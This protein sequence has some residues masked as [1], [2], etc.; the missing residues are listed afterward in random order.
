M[1]FGARIGA[2]RTD[3]SLQ[4]R[5]RVKAVVSARLHVAPADEQ[6][7]S[8]A[9]RRDAPSPQRSSTLGAVDPAIE[10]RPDQ[11][12]EECSSTRSRATERE[13]VLRERCHQTHLTETPHARGS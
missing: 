6:G 8:Q 1:R 3:T 10:T 5:F 12:S 4:L 9:A 13:R 7:A 11:P 2:H